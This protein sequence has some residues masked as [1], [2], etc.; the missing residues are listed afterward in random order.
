M[1]MTDPTM[2][3]PTGRSVR[4]TRP[5]TQERPTLWSETKPSPKTTELWL[6]LAGIAVLAIIYNVSR[7]A[8]LNLWRAMPARHGR[9]DGVHREPRFCEI[10]KSRRRPRRARRR[11]AQVALRSGRASRTRA[12]PPAMSRGLV[13]RG[14]SPGGVVAI[15]LAQR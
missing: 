13:D 11:A 4:Q 12:R 6:T 3:D 1:T 14:H 8:S 9:R 10:G 5:T 2:T 15:R 7:D